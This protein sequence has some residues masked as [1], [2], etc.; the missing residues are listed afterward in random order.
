VRIVKRAFS[1]RRKMMMKLL[2][3]DWPASK[4]ES[5]FAALK[6]PPQVR[7]EVLSREQFVELAKRLY[8]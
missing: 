7:A 1:Q 2:R 5:V 4:L 3:E 8:E 6:I